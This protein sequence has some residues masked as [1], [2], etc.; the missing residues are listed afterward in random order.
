MRCLTRGRA[1]VAMRVSRICACARTSPAV[2][3]DAVMI[4]TGLPLSGDAKPWYVSQPHG[5]PL[6]LDHDD[7]TIWAQTEKLVRAD[8]SFMPAAEWS[9]R[10][11]Q[12]R[13]ALE[14]VRSLS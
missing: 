1:K 11:V 12:R 14:G 8:P 3:G 10:F 2:P 7:D 9:A 13:R 5:D 4:N 6:D